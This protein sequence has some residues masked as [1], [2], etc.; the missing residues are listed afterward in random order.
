[1]PKIIYAY[2]LD[3]RQ[4]GLFRK[5][6][7]SEPAECQ[8]IT[9]H[10]EDCPLLKAGTCA[11]RRIFGSCP[12]GEV[13]HQ[14]GPTGRS[15]K[16]WDWIQEKRKE[17]ADVGTDVSAPE[18]KLA[19]I[20]GYVWLPY[21]HADMCKDVPFLR[22]SCAFVSGIDFIKCEN[23]TLE[24]VLTLIDFRPQA[25]MGGEIT[26]YQRK[27][28]P[29]LIQHIRECDPEM[30]QQLIAVRPQYDVAPNYVGRK[31]LVKTLKAGIAIP[32]KD[33]RYP[34]PWTWDGTKLTTNSKHAYGDTW[35]GMKCGDVEL[36]LTPD[37]KTVTV[38]RSNE[39]VTPETV[40]VD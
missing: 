25:L 17:F 26:D 19:F 16:I 22:H 35:G 28:V 24:N 11:S 7:K 39:W 12:Y 5:A 14:R 13:R 21:P 23:W 10:N 31:A 8:T 1:M 6:S 27:S 34:V 40:F 36:S 18:N 32:P 38:V 2:V 4:P 20:G 15:N 37:E 33:D 3:P 9:C 29:L 30:W